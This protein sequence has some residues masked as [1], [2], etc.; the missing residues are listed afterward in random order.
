M[1]V[2]YYHFTAREYLPNI[3]REGLRRAMV[4]AKI[5][6][7]EVGRPSENPSIEGISAGP[8]GGCCW[9]EFQAGNDDER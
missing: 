3:A 5:A 1:H 8:G 4:A 9:G 7:L 6:N 2:T